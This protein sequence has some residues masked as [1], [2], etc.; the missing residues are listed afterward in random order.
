MLHKCNHNKSNKRVGQK[1]YSGR[2]SISLT[3]TLGSSW[4]C[5]KPVASLQLLKGCKDATHIH[6]PVMRNFHLKC[7]TEPQ[8]SASCRKCVPEP[9]ERFWNTSFSSASRPLLVTQAVIELWVGSYSLKLQSASLFS[10]QMFITWMD[11]LHCIKYPSGLCTKHTL[12]NAGGC[13]AAKAEDLSH[14]WGGQQQ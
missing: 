12:L 4:T 3:H 14:S 2:K 8:L 7:I 10:P 1:L 11:S 6:L 13:T 9:L 5:I